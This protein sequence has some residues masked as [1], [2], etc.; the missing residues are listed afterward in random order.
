MQKFPK[1]QDYLE[2]RRVALTPMGLVLIPLPQPA[3]T[4]WQYSF[5]VGV[6]WPISFFLRPQQDADAD[7]RWLQGCVFRCPT[8]WASF[9]LSDRDVR[10]G[11]LYTK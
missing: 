3:G 9:V 8:S 2:Q 5:E 11:R 6:H 10:M 1:W 7:L 4:L